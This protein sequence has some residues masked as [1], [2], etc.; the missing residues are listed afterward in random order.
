MYFIEACTDGSYVYGGREFLI[1]SEAI[2][3]LDDVESARSGNEWAKIIFTFSAETVHGVF[4]WEVEIIEYF[5]MD[6]AS[7]LGASIKD[8]PAD[9]ILKDEVT[10]TLQ[11]GWLNPKKIPPRLKAVKG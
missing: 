3:K 1:S 5:E 6:V 7:F 2:E 10:F 4:S 11:D 9:V 8:Y